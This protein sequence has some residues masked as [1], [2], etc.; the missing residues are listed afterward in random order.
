MHTITVTFDNEEFEE[1]KKLKGKT[2]WHDFI[3]NNAK[4]AKALQTYLELVES[5]EI[6]IETKSGKIPILYRDGHIMILAGKSE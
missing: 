3:L 2:S 6:T 5:G 4:E 1:L